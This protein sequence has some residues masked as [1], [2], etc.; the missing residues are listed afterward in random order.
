MAETLQEL[1]N[2]IRLKQEELALA[3]EEADVEQIA[4]LEAEIDELQ[5]KHFNLKRTDR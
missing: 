1:Q 4:E 3:Y 2:E 5:R